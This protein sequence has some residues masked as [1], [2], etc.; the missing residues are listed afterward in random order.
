MEY[1]ETYNFSE[2]SLLAA[3]SFLGLE[4]FKQFK[5]LSSGN[6]VFEEEFL[7]KQLDGKSRRRKGKLQQNLE[8]TNL[9]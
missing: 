8:K 4:K 1:M 2:A 7:R 9:G 6:Q 5:L 3:Q